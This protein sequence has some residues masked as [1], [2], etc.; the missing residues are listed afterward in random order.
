MLY[1]FKVIDLFVNLTY[2]CLV[3]IEKKKIHDG[4]NYSNAETNKISFIFMYPNESE[5]EDRVRGC[6]IE[7]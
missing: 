3:F 1:Y 5:C 7:A 2:N 6:I 4:Y